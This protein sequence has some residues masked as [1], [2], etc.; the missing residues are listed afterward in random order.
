MTLNTRAQLR[1]FENILDFNSFS[2]HFHLADCLHVL[3]LIEFKIVIQSMKHFFSLEGEGC[4]PRKAARERSKLRTNKLNHFLY[5]K[6]VES[7]FIY[8]LVNSLPDTLT[9]RWISKQK[10]FPI[11]SYFVGMW[12]SKVWKQTCC[13]CLCMS[14][15]LSTTV[16][17]KSNFSCIYS[18]GALFLVT[19]NTMHQTIVI[20]NK[21]LTEGTNIWLWL[22]WEE[23]SL[24]SHWLNK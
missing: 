19:K 9:T 24:A 22:E 20:S 23:M 5:W 14:S 16:L 15:G 11:C 6:V 10:A 1:S 2:S 8:Y 7:Y 18:S 17:W 3:T 21:L 12:V 4:L 13:L